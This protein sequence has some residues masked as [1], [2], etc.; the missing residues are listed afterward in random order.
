MLWCIF[1]VLVSPSASNKYTTADYL[2]S[3]DYIICSQITEPT[4]EYCEKLYDHLDKYCDV[5]QS[6]LEQLRRKDSEAGEAIANYW[7]L[8]KPKFTQKYDAQVL[9]KLKKTLRESNEDVELFDRKIGKVKILWDE[10]KEECMKN[11]HFCDPTGVLF[12]SK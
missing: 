3:L 6:L 2:D 1:S 9:D 5:L 7:A 8:G 10:F 4:T 12:Q 11:K